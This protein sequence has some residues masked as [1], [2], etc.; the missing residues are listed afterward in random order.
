MAETNPLRLLDKGV[1]ERIF[2]IKKIFRPCDVKTRD[3]YWSP[4][5]YH[6][7][8]SGKPPRTHMID[9]KVVPYFSSDMSAAMEV[10]SKMENEGWFVEMGNDDSRT[11]E[12]WFVEFTRSAP[13]VLYAGNGEA[14][15]LPQAICD[16]ALEAHQDYETDELRKQTEDDD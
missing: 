14:E 5:E 7:I 6:Y 9:A 2:G 8:P 10:I 11:N 3:D 16:A 13:S 12:H 15:T 4:E 1:A